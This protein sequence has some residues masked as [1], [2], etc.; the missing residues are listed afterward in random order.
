MNVSRCYAFSNIGESNARRFRPTDSARQRD[1]QKVVGLALEK[2]S[3]LSRLQNVRMGAESAR[4]EYSKVRGGL[5]GTWDGDLPTHRGGLQDVCTCNVLQRC[6]DWRFGI[7]GGVATTT[8]T[9]K[10]PAG[11]GQ[12]SFGLAPESRQFTGQ[13]GGLGKE[14]IETWPPPDR[15]LV[16]FRPGRRCSLV[17]W[18]A[19]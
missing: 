8:A 18:V 10:P 9:A 2:P 13:L 4:R 3:D 5:G 17:I 7:M 15:P 12:H 6:L 19:S 1:H 11:S 16:T 14:K